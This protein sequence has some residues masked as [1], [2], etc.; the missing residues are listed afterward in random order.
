MSSRKGTS[1]FTQRPDCFQL[2]HSQVYGGA[3]GCLH[4]CPW[5]V[6]RP[7]GPQIHVGIK[8]L[9]LFGF[10]CVSRATGATTEDE[11]G[12]DNCLRDANCGYSVVIERHPPSSET[13]QELFLVGTVAAGSRYMPLSPKPH[14]QQA[15]ATCEDRGHYTLEVSRI[16]LRVLEAEVYKKTGDRKGVTRHPI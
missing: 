8:S 7:N 9:V 13:A 3:H 15:A 5:P 6:V 10:P 2:Y 1:A 11:R 12:R 16:R 14:S 4:V